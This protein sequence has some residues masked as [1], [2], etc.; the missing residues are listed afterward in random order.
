VDA[1]GA[2]WL[3]AEF[4]A[5]V[6]WLVVELP[7]GAVDWLVVEFEGWVWA[8]EPVAGAPVGV[9]VD[10]VEADGCVVVD[11]EPELGALVCGCAAVGEF[12]VELLG[13]C[14]KAAVPTMRQTA[15]LA[16][17]CLFMLELLIKAWFATPKQPAGGKSVPL[18]NDIGCRP[19]FGNI[20][21]FTR[22]NRQATHKQLK[23]GSI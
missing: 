6:D 22:L 15:V 11:D 21:Q 10:C 4:V 13:D 12:V 2:D 23:G 7:V 14:A 8:V 19:L 1:A 5:G 18:W 20:W 3:V 17:S 9:V 16:R